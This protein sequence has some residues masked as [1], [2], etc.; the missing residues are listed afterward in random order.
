MQSINEKFTDAEFKRIKRIKNLMKLSWH[1]F[2]MKIIELAE[3]EI[4][5]ALKKSGAT[6]E[7]IKKILK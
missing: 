3:E 7:E 2:I 5:S 1:D 4:P 6:D